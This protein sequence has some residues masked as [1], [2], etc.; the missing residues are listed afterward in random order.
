MVLLSC[1][2]PL[3]DRSNYDI[4]WYRLLKQFRKKNESLTMSTLDL[5]ALEAAD[6]FRASWK[7]MESAN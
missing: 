2:P 6:Y 5:G 3:E 7:L 4:K 1:E